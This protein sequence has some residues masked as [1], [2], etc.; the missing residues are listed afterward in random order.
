MK[1]FSID[2]S[3]EPND[4][5]RPT[6]PV[7]RPITDALAVARFH[8]EAAGGVAAAGGGGHCYPET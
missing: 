7:I 3:A 8:E 1:I 2:G 6:S 5:N 4:R